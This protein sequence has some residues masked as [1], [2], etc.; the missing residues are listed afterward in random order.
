MDAKHGDTH[1]N[2]NSL[3]VSTHDIKSESSRSHRRGLSVSFAEKTDVILDAT[4]QAITESLKN[5][6]N[7]GKLGSEFAINYIILKV[8]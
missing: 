4:K 2:E 7:T 3:F 5:M 6:E 8:Y 1:D